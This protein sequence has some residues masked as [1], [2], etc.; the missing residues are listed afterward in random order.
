M[1]NK[2][3]KSKSSPA[4]TRHSSGSSDAWK[5]L[6]IVLVLLISFIAG[7]IGL[8]TNSPSISVAA[9]LVY[10]RLAGLALLCYKNRV[11]IVEIVL[12]LGALVLRIFKH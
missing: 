2:T 12:E 9:N 5:W 8:I 10:V 3:S 1:K 11:A 4:R 7:I 6:N